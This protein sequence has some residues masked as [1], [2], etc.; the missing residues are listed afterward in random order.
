LSYQRAAAWLAEESDFDSL[1]GKQS[2]LFSTGPRASLWP[3]GSLI[4][5]V[6]GVLSPGV[7]RPGREADRHSPSTADTKNTWIYASTPPH[8]FM[9]QC[10]IKCAQGCI[11]LYIYRAYIEIYVFNTMQLISLF[12]SFRGARGSVVG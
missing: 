2:L 4:E 3:T 1:K 6:I 5:R 7:K 11:Y 12:M 9:K 8:F 10:L